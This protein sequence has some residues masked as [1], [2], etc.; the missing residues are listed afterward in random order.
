[1]VNN[2]EGSAALQTQ[3]IY[4]EQAKN[5]KANE[6]K[7]CKQERDVGKALSDTSQAIGWTCSTTYRPCTAK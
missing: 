6:S 3:V 5:K 2:Q 4:G 1:M 7:E